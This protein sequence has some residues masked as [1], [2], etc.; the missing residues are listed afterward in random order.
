M[1]LIT[2]CL[3]TGVITKYEVFVNG[4]LE[5]HN[6][7]SHAEY[8]VFTS[9]GWLDPSMPSIPEETNR[10]TIPPPKS[11][12]NITDLQA[13]STYQIRVVSTNMAGS[14]PS[15]WITA[16]TMEGGLYKH[17]LC[18]NVQLIETYITMFK[19]IF[20]KSSPTANVRNKEAN[21]Q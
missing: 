15:E 4:P 5:S 11:S 10:S 12:T 21:I 2:F 17:N 6:Q 9:S 14:V 7:S 16:R 13:F 1:S 19:K 20:K 8:L 3:C 18:K